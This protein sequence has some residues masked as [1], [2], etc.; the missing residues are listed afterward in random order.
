VL[1][2]LAWTTSPAA[3]HSI[4]MFDTTTPL[5]VKGTVVRF[6]LVNPHA[7]IYL[8]QA[9]ET[10][11]G[12]RWVVDGGPAIFQLERRGVTKDILKTGDVIEVC[13]FVLRE[14]VQPPQAPPAPKNSNLDASSP[15]LTGR[16]LHAHVLVMPDGSRRFWSDYGH[17]NK[18]LRPG[19]TRS[20]LVG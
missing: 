16:V 17:L 5:W 2:V 12:E 11:H 4:V 15:T 18:C 1:V 19:E 7:R 13:G 9:S 10:G 8:D 6:D 20:S 14:S 3:H